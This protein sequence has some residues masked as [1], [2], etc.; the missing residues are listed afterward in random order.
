METSDDGPAGRRP[1]ADPDVV[2][3][4]GQQRY[5][6]LAGGQVAGWAAY[7]LRD[8]G[9]V[10]THTRIGEAFEGGGLGSR[11]ARAALDDVRGRGLEVIPQCPFIAGYI[12]RHPEYLDLVEAGS[13]PGLQP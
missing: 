5:E 8:D 10:F 2:D 12:R 13:R 1:T 7:I 4:P 9:I 6:V 3:D 11:L